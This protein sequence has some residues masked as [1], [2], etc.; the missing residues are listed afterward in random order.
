LAGTAG[1]RVFN[2]SVNVEAQE[3]QSHDEVQEKG[4]FSCVVLGDGHEKEA[5]RTDARISEEYMPT[6]ALRSL[7]EAVEDGGSNRIVFTAYENSGE[8]DV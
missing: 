5:L 3:N 1:Y 4:G 2:E 6:V 8:S 7:L